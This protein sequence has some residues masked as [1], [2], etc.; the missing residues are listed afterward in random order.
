M[1]ASSTAW[2]S[3]ARIAD[4]LRARLGDLAPG[5]AVT[6]EVT[7]AREFGVARNTVRRALGVLADEGLIET[8]PGRG[9]LVRAAGSPGP[10]AAGRPA[11]RRI[12][13]DLQ[14]EIES[15][16]LPPGA[17]LPSES[18]L[19]STYG[20]SRGTARQAL[21]VLVSVGLVRVE[22]GRGRFVQ[23]PQRRA[24]G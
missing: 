3:Y 22:Q 21:S 10:D 11:Y 5:S 18:A 23:T 16:E 9:R 20:V 1:S 14:R 8:V 24:D 2:G 4:T 12:A 19:T 6:A 7:L 13:E 17:P 15:G